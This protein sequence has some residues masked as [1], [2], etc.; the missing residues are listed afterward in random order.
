MKNMIDYENSIAKPKI[1][2]P[3]EGLEEKISKMV[4]DQIKERM[5]KD[6]EKIIIDTSIKAEESQ[7]NEEITVNEVNNNE[8]EE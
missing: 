6:P 3:L 4:D 2:D 7:E 8:E 1:A 5:Q